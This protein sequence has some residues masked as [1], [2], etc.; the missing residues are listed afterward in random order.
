MKLKL[1]KRT[2]LYQGRVFNV[3]VDD[4]EYPSGNKS[5]REVA[6][7]IGGAVV[8]AVFPDEEI[9]LIN[10]HRY[11]FDEFIWE[12]PAGKLNVGEDPLECA[13]RELEEETGYRADHW[14]KLTAIYTTPGF[15]SEKLHIYLA[16]QLTSAPKGRQLEEG[17]LT[18]TMKK[19]P[20]TEAIMMIERQEI[21]DGKT[22]CGVL[23]GERMLRK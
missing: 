21:V 23:L 11:P 17:E 20:L 18:M 13:K 6:E 15:C 12:L 19:L 14:K 10:Q 1:L 4:V 16:T 7:H 2:N 3:I 8:L 9:L 5:V 22:I